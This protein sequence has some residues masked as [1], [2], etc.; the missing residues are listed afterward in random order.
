MAIIF[1]TQ[2]IQADI[3][4]KLIAVFVFT[5][6]STFLFAQAPVTDSSIVLKKKKKDWSKVDIDRAGDH[7]LFQLSSDHWTGVPDSISSH[8]KGL[9]R[10]LNLYFM[11]D[12][13]FKTDPRWSV[14]FGVGVGSSN[15]NFKRMGVDLKASGTVLPFNNLD[16]ANHF[17]RYKLVTA[18]LEI[19]VELRY[20]FHPD[21]EA[22]S[23]K[24]ALGVKVGTMI[25]AHTKGKTLQDKYGA[26]V[27]SYSAKEN[28]KRFFNTTRLVGTARVGIGHFSLFGAYQL[29]SFL[30]DG[31]GADIRPLQ[32][33]L[34]LSGL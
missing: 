7:L 26:S 14:A 34:T 10:G 19:P 8:I 23:W 4:K 29:N 24:L 28:S 22:K 15:I 25:N 31:A 9:S 33:G 12:K 32:I 3:M 17:K 18:Y 20:T 6:I 2:S 5:L 30:K 11:I 1:A 21:N 16:S 13:P 27:N